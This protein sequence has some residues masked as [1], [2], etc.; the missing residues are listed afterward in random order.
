MSLPT[1]GSLA[2]VGNFGNP[3]Y[4]NLREVWYEAAYTQI[5]ANVSITA[6]TEATANTV[7]TASAL[8]FNGTQTALIEFFTPRAITASNTGIVFC[9]YDGSSSA[10]QMGRLISSTGGVVESPVDVSRRLIPSAAS[11]TYS[12][13]AFSTAGTATVTA[14]A[15]GTG[16]FMPA[17]VRITVRDA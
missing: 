10:G 7:V 13:R 16:V 8:T 9:L 14:G 4:Q 3:V 1:S 11:H 12:I 5:T 17:F 15:G 2:T 6:T